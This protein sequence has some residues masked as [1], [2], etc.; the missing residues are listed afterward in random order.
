MKLKVVS[1]IFGFEDVKEAYLKKMDDFFYELDCGEIVFTLIDPLSIT[2][3]E[4]DLSESYKKLLEVKSLDDVKIFNIVTIHTPIE[5]STINFLAPIMINE[6]KKLLV[7][8][9]LD[10]KRYN[11][12]LREPIKNFL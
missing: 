6:D 8:I 7:Q 4:F 1:P 5:E 10:D 2:K 11:F 3:Y 9:A 12:A